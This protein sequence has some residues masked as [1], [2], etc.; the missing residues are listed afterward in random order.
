MLKLVKTPA[1][2][3]PQMALTMAGPAPAVSNSAHP[4]LTFA[5]TFVSEFQN[6]RPS[7]LRLAARNGQLLG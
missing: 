6:A 3:R 7:P 5:Q 4:G 1:K 2:P